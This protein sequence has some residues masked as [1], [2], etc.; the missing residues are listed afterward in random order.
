MN[1]KFGLYYT[2]EMIKVAKERYLSGQSVTKIAKDLNIDRH[3]LGKHLFV[4]QNIEKRD[5]QG[6]KTKYNYDSKMIK[7]IVNEYKNGLGL[8]PLAVK[9]SISTNVVRKALSYHGA[10]VAKTSSKKKIKVFNESVFDK[11]DTEEKA[12]WLGFLYADGSMNRKRYTLEV[13][14]AEKDRDHLIKLCDFLGLDRKYIK[15]KKV[16]LGDKIFEANRLEVFSKRNFENLERLGCPPRKSLTL[17]F[18]DSSKVPAHLL[19]HFMRGYFD[20]DGTISYTPGKAR[21]QAKFLLLGT[22]EFLI[23]YEN[24]LHKRSKVNFSR[25]TPR[26]KTNAFQITHGGNLQAE[27]LYRFLYSKATIYLQRKH[28]K[29]IAVLDRNVKNNQGAKSVEG[30]IPNTEVTV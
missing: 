9:Y 28:D 22:K 1:K 15:A 18:P 19:V 2:E 23:E 12:Y 6:G 20:G 21:S 10:V 4:Y 27:K 11:I 30:E 25:T 29:F 17:L 24:V 13:S 8:K 26:Q 7:D 14:L 3:Q 16:K 5:K